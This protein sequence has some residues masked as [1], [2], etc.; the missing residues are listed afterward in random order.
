MQFSE[1]WLRSLVKPPLD[2]QALAHLLTMAGLEVEEMR[3]M[4]PAFGN[5][6]VAQVISVEKHPDAD[7][8]NLCKVDA[9]EAAPLQIV[10]GAP[11]VAAGM[12]VPCALIGAVLPG[13]TIKKAKV[14]GIESF[15][16][17]CSARELGITQEDTGG[18]L[19]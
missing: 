18:L 15:G 12:K 16:M 3:P 17:L 4:A 2:S 5:V 7:K 11:N 10:C 13:I 9:G 1:N 8:L 14:R 19:P 6:V